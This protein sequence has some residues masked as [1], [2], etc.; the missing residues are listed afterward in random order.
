MPQLDVHFGDGH[1]RAEFDATLLSAGH[2]NLCLLQLPSSQN[3][4]ANDASRTAAIAALRDLLAGNP[5]HARPA[6]SQLVAG[7]GPVLINAL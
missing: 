2:L 3:A 6:L 1:T 7:G 5:A 4:V